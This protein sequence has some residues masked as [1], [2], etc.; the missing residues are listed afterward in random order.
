M[1]DDAYVV[2]AASRLA[3]RMLAEIEVQAKGA[4]G[5]MR[6]DQTGALINL[7]NGLVEKVNSLS[8][9]KEIGDVPRKVTQLKRSL[10][11]VKAD[12]ASLAVTK[13]AEALEKEK[14]AKANEV[15][16]KKRVEE[17]AQKEKV[18]TELEKVNAA[19]LANVATL[20][21]L[22]FRD[23]IRVLNDL[24]DEVSSQ[25]AKDAVAL[26]LD[27]VNRIKDFH[28]YLVDKV[29]GFKSAH[30]WV[31]DS[32]DQKAL[33]VGGKKVPWVDVYASR[34]DIV[35]ELINGLVMDDKATKD[36]HLREKT[37]LM[38]N[39]A[40]SLA[41]FYKEIASAQELAKR[42]ATSAAEQFDVDA[43]II[44]QLLPEFFK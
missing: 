15:A 10:A 8:N 27:R 22:Q 33:T 23:A 6:P 34:V 21:Q 31:I 5:L 30:G 12:T 28:T 4:E 39:A 43:D 36:L 1:Y 26:A 16:E 41:L 9:M 25:E 29:P 2:K 14:K 37:R 19:E 18:K 42:L 3:E 17:E 24:L 11:S 38:T 13:R 7:A 20:K 32:A 40:L 44:K 35:G